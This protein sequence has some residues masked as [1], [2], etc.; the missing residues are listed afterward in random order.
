M[1]QPKGAHIQFN[2]PVLKISIWWGIYN[3]VYPNFLYLPLLFIKHMFIKLIKVSYE[4]WTS[5]V[6]GRSFLSLW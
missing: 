4:L 3:G 5:I 1:L 2:V 6:R